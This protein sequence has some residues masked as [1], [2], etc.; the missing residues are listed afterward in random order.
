MFYL[1]VLS[2]TV[3]QYFNHPMVNSCPALWPL[4][5]QSEGRSCHALVFI[6]PANRQSCVYCWRTAVLQSGW[7]SLEWDQL[8]RMS[9]IPLYHNPPTPH[10][11]PPVLLYIRAAS[12]C[13]FSVFFSFSS[14]LLCFSTYLLYSSWIRHTYAQYMLWWIQART[15]CQAFVWSCDQVRVLLRQHRVRLRRALPTLPTSELW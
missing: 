6:I 1:I 2:R 11:P 14:H 4:D 13:L 9:Q 7:D 10:P 12:L 3:S 15:V 8:Y 5:W